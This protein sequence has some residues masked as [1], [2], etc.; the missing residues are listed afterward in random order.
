LNPGGLLDKE[1]RDKKQGVFEKPE[2]TFYL[3]LS[4]IGRDDLYVA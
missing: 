2:A 1:R 3:T 4:F